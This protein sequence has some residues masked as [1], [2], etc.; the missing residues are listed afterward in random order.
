MTFQRVVEV[1][2]VVALC[3][4]LVALQGCATREPTIC[5]MAAKNPELRD[6]IV[7]SMFGLPTAACK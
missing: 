6:P 3:L 7:A 5:E 1:V 4:M 2:V